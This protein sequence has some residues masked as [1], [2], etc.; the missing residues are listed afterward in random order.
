MELEIFGT[1]FREILTSFLAKMRKNIFNFRHFANIVNTYKYAVLV[2]FEA[3]ADRIIAYNCV[4]LL[5]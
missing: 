5:F 4:E 1:R 3:I 2:N